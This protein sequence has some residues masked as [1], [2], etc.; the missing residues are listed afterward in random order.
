MEK[1]GFPIKETV[2]VSFFHEIKKYQYISSTL[3]KINCL[4]VKKTIEKY[5][6]KK[7]ILQKTK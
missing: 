5:Y 6:K 7:I 1:S 3:T 2:F 4:L